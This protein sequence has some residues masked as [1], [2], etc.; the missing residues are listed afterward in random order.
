VPPRNLLTKDAVKRL[1]AIRAL[2]ELGMGF[3]LATHDLEIRGAGELLD[4]EQSG[5]LQEIGF[6]LYTQLVERAVAP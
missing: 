2:E 4:S 6:S 3:T 5:H 1:E